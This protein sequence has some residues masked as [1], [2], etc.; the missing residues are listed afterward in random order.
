M[1]SSNIERF[2]EITAKVFSVLYEE[3]PVPTNLFAEAHVSPATCYSEFL[4]CDVP[5][6]EAEFFVASVTWLGD[7]GYLRCK[8]QPAGTAA[9]IGAVL[10][11]KGLEV[12]KTIPDSLNGKKTIGEQLVA[13]AKSG[14]TAA[15]KDG[16][17]AAL[18][19]GAVMLGAA[20]S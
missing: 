3:F 2:D 5:S 6:T 10:T 7:A 4:G 18:A 9:F 13:A 17:K 11:T 16:V 14:A 12:L 1:P 15:L 20:L 8:E 19:K